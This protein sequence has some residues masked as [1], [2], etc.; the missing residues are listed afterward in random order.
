MPAHRE[1]FPRLFVIFHLL[2]EMDAS[3]H[4]RKN[5][6]ATG[7]NQNHYVCSKFGPDPHKN[8]SFMLGPKLNAMTPPGG[9]P[10]PLTSIGRCWAPR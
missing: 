8:I 3:E 4:L 2:D 1:T 6:E 7:R 10:P 9:P 5:Q